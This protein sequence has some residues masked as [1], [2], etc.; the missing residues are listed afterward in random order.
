VDKQRKNRQIKNRKKNQPSQEAQA[1]AQSQ[2]SEPIKEP[3][4][5]DVNEWI[6]YGELINPNALDSELYSFDYN[7]YIELFDPEL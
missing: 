5:T 7:A 3:Q 2:A 4:S 1:Q 6:Q